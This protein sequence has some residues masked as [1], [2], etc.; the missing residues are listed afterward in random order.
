MGNTALLSA[1]SNRNLS[2]VKLLVRDLGA[3]V[4]LRSPRHMRFHYN[5]DNLERSEVLWTFTPL[6]FAIEKEDACMVLLIL[7]L[8]ADPLVRGWTR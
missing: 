5:G 3:D 2:M 1:I 8:G 4:N 7:S 6:L